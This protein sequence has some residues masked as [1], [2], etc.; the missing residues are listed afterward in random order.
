MS[1]F[2]GIGL[3]RFGPTIFGW[4]IGRRGN[5]SRGILL[6]CLFAATVLCARAQ[7][8]PA[9]PVG[10]L[11]IT[12][13]AGNEA[14]Q[15]KRELEATKAENAIL[16]QTLNDRDA[17]IKKLQDANTKNVADLT[18]RI[19]RTEVDDATKTGQLINAEAEIQRLTVMT[20]FLLTNGR[21]KCTFSVLCF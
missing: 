8:C 20:H 1:E 9:M 2:F 10:T 11:C 14:A 17:D 16:T 5:Q 4:M 15:N 6:L 19:H 12:Q 13:Q 18:E 21:K 7:V 3:G